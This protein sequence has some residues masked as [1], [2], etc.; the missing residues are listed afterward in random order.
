MNNTII[1]CLLS[2]KWKEKTSIIVLF[3]SLLLYL[4]KKLANEYLREDI[5]NCK[6]L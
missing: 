6:K 4:Y 5:C 2:N 3:F 1:N